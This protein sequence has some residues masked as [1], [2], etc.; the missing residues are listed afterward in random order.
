M[1]IGVFGVLNKVCFKNSLVMFEKKHY[2]LQVVRFSTCFL[3]PFVS[4]V[5]LSFAWFCFSLLSF[6]VLLVVGY[7]K[8]LC[9]GFCFFGVSLVWL[10]V[11]C[12][13]FL[14]CFCLLFL[15]GL[16]VR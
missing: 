7:I 8:L 3:N 2:F 15:E 9:S 5:G 14:V 4:Y 16:R 11:M 12:C 1:H 10:C 6:L 13:F